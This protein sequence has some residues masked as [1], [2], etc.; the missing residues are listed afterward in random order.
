METKAWILPSEGALQTHHGRLSTK[1]PSR[2]FYSDQVW[3]GLEEGGEEEMGLR[4]FPKESV[5]LWFLIGAQWPCGVVPSM[6]RGNVHLRRVVLGPPHCA[7]GVTVGSAQA[8]G[9]VSSLFLRALGPQSWAT[10][11]AIRPTS[12]VTSSICADIITVYEVFWGIEAICRTKRRLFLHTSLP[13]VSLLPRQEGRHLVFLSCP[14]STLHDQVFDTYALANPSFHNC[15]GF[16]E[17]LAIHS[18]GLIYSLLSM[19]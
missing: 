3:W 11:Y 13:S 10:G 12:K 1:T 9:S 8:P 6:T 5:K 7:P 18:Q 19:G 2:Q 4:T 16:K 17:E 15:I 14:I